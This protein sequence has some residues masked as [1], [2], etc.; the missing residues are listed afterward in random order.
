MKVKCNALLLLQL[1][2]IRSYLKFWD[3]FFILDAYYPDTLLIVSKDV[4]IRGYFRR[5]KGVASKKVLGSPDLGE[6]KPES[7][8]STLQAIAMQYQPRIIRK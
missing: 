7:P 8:V 1:A 2:C 6:Q 5:Q 4:K 3:T